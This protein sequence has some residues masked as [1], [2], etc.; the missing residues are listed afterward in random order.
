[1]DIDFTE[2]PYFRPTAYFAN[3]TDLDSGLRKYSMDFS[4]AEL[5]EL[6][7]NLKDIEEKHGYYLDVTERIGDK[8]REIESKK[9]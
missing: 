2:V 1:M 9:E 3:Y 8:V 5:K 7:I 6:Y 4:Y